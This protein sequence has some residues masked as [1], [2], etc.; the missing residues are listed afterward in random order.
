M[1]TPLPVSVPAGFAPVTAIG[2][3]QADSTFA[4]VSAASP[5]PVFF[6]RT[7]IAAAL[8]GTTS[9]S[10]IAGPFAPVR[11]RPVILALSGTWSGS[12]KVLRS[13]D[14]GSTKLPLTV[15]GTPWAMFSSNCCEAVWEEG[16]DGAQ[17]FLDVT[18]SSGAL[19]YRLEQ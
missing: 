4:Q 17:L 1:P 16:A 5:L 2:F 8:S 14:N 13:T 3:A 9:T 12:V 6:A 11:D 18:L 10:L 7:E 19:T 15:G